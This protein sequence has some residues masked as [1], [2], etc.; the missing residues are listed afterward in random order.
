MVVVLKEGYP[1]S[2]PVFI[3]GYMGSGKTT[4]GRAL[5]KALGR[6]FIDLDGYIVN[7]FRRSVNEIFAERGEEGFRTL[8]ASMLREAGEFE[9]VV[10]ACGGGTP[11]FAGN[12]DYMLSRG[13][14]VY[15]DTPLDCI[16]RRLVTNPHKR[17]L[18]KGLSPEGITKLVREQTEARE[19][20]YSRAA[21][22]FSG[23]ELENR[24]EID[25]SVA[26]FIN[27]GLPEIRIPGE[28]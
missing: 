18:L 3:M 8:E 7:R 6:E 10:V 26:A 15:L 19:P 1:A 2:L 13:L 20:Y 16:V 4:F 14:T 27:M 5:A 28:D 22:C 23:E 25:N 17:P 11:C 21:V 24:R 9:G 12:M